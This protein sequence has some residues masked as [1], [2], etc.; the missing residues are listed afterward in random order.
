VTDD[1][2][3]IPAIGQ[4]TDG[5]MELLPHVEAVLAA[6]APTQP[7]HPAAAANVAYPMRATSSGWPSRR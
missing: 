1:P 3:A 6:H 7:I 5:I 4:L 2:K